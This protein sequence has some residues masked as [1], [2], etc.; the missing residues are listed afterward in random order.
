MQ[1]NMPAPGG[2]AVSE[3]VCCWSLSLLQVAPL[4]TECLFAEWKYNHYYG[5]P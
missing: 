1:L 2:K 3:Y 4:L 5:W